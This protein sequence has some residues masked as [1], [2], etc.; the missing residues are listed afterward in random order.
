MFPKNPKDLLKTL[1]SLRLFFSYEKPNPY[2]YSFSGKITLLDGS[3]SGLN[4][5][6][7]ALRGCS[8]RNTEYMYG[9][10]S[11]TGHK[12][13]IMLNSVNSRNKQSKVE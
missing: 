5:S 7:F 3:Q 9:V 4:N 13:K 8:L 10:V 6:N 2:I 11:Y 1:S 12:S